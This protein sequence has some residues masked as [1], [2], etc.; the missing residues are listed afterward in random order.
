MVSG[1][2]GAGKTTALQTIGERLTDQGYTVGMIT[3][4][5]ASGLVDTSI[6]D[7]TDGTVVEI[8]GGCFCCNFDELLQASSSISQQD[9]DILLAEPVGSCTD[10]VATVINPLRSMYADDFAVAP[11]TVILDPDRVQSYLDETTKTLP[12]E[13]RYIFDMQVEEADV[14][15]L[16][17]TDTLTSDETAR[18]AKKLQDRVGNRPVI[19]LS[20]KQQDGIDRWVSEIFTGEETDNVSDGDGQE[21]AEGRALTDIDYDTYADGEAKLGWVNLTASLE[22]PFEPSQFTTE[23]MHRV[24]QALRADS[25]EVAHL[26][27]SLEAA[28]ELCHANLTATDNEPRYANINLGS[29]T[30]GRLV[31]NA[32]AVGNPE[33]IRTIASDAL[34]ATARTVNMEIT[35]EKEQAFRPDYP[36]P[37]HRI[38]DAVPASGLDT[39]DLAQFD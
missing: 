17:K 24:H 35:I 28:G 8:P 21:T 15:V 11:L 37:T 25:I 23:L 20:A 33:E 38:D 13:V 26:K 22:G 34:T 31:F 2:L 5:Q 32:R 3:N 14:I 29:V 6:L 39:S 4:D 12:E 10:L 1:F 19:P 18:L 7:R 30:E 36:E 27:F 16:N 9:V